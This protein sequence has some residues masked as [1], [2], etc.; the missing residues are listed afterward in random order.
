MPIRSRP[1]RP[2]KEDQPAPQRKRTLYVPVEA[3]EEFERLAVEQGISAHA[4]MRQALLLGLE[5]IKKGPGTP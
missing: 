2:G 4:L 1:G 5:Q 3:D